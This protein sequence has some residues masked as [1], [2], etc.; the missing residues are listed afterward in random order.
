MN[1]VKRKIEEDT[2]QGLEA[3]K[4]QRSVPNLKS[5]ITTQ[6]NAYLVN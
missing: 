4:V 1:E 2:V 3:G 6:F 5:S